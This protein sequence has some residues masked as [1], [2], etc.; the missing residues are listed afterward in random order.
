MP[1]ASGPG[2]GQRVWEAVEGLT[3]QGMPY[4]PCC[5]TL[6]ELFLSI[7]EDLLLPS[8]APAAWGDLFS[9]NIAK[10]WCALMV[11]LFTMIGIL[12]RS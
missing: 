9:R 5:S 7:P 4:Y 2:E 6:P 12:G 3:W 8:A 10:R 11:F 1:Q